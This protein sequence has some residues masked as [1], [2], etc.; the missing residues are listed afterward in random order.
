MI[1]GVAVTGGNKRRVQVRAERK[2]GFTAEKRQ[3]FLD[4][5]A[6]CANV[7]RA[8][9]AAG[10]SP[11][12]VNYHRRSDPVFAGQCDGAMDAAYFTLEAMQL[13]EAAGGGHYLPG[14]DA[15]AAAPGAD[16]V[17]PM[18]DKELALHLLRL[19]KR[20]MGQRTGRAGQEPKRVGEKELNDSILAKLEVLDRRLRLKREQ[21]RKLKTV[22]DV[23]ALAQGKTEQPRS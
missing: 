14:P 11:E 21:V 1:D 5:L 22:G 19:R 10:V 13:E 16:G 7:T 8:A 6:G 23:K 18:P 20:P 9:A 3:R 4:H 12:T 2:D 15:A 17:G